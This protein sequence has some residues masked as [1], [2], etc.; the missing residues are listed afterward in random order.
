M[1]KISIVVPVYNAGEFLFS[2]IESIERNTFK[3]YEIIIVDDGSEKFTADICDNCLQEFSNVSVYHTVNQGVSAARNYGI[4]MAKGEFLTFVDADDT[5]DSNYLSELYNLAMDTG[6]QMAVVGHK[7][8]FDN[9]TKERPPKVN[10]D[11]LLN[12]E[13][14]IDFLK[15]INRHI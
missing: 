15:N 3:D 9:Y 14:K 6:C 1:E 4:Q 13:T 5:V 12:N 11:L 8:I 7:E 2:C 10:K